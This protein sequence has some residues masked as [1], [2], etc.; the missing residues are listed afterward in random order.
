[1]AKIK[2]LYDQIE[3]ELETCDAQ[4]TPTICSNLSNDKDKACIVET[5]AETALSMQIN[6][7]QAIV[8]V[9]KQFNP[10]GL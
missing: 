3:K 2:E 7:S 8:Q 9:E 6:I 5:I 1:M 10:N 4:E